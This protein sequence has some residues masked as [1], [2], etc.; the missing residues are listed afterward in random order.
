MN[1]L[2]VRIIAGNFSVGNDYIFLIVELV[3]AH[4]FRANPIDYLGRTRP[5]HSSLTFVRISSGARRMYSKAMDWKDGRKVRE[6]AR[7]G[8]EK[9]V[10][11]I[12]FEH[13]LR[14]PLAE[15]AALPE[16]AE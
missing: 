11:D 13:F 6:I 2:E 12:L 5:A 1:S 14:D 8:R 4:V 3:S 10:S 15:T 9:A 16:A 7:Q